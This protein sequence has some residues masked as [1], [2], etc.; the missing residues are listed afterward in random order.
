METQIAEST[1]IMPSLFD[2]TDDGGNYL[3]HIIRPPENAHLWHP[4]MTAKD[5][6]AAAVLSGEPLTALCGHKWVSKRDP[7]KYPVCSK[8]IHLATQYMQA[9]GE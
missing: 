6:A 3:T 8:C 9:E 2:E 4:G 1:L 7:E 5:V